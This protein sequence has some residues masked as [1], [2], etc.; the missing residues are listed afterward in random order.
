MHKA[1]YSKLVHWDNPEGW[2]GEGGERGVQ[3]GVT[4]VHPWLIDVNAY[5]NHH[6]IVK[7]L[8]SD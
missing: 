6:N 3:D 4:H 2:N 7:K 1:E 8:A 5:K